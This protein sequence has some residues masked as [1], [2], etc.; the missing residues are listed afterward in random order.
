MTPNINPKCKTC[1]DTG[2]VR[3][4]GDELGGVCGTAFE[5][6]QVMKDCPDCQRNGVVLKINKARLR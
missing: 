1:N 5:L 2:K 4:D 3:D 6:S